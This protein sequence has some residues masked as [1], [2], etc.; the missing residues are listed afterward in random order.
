MI[1]ISFLVL[2]IFFGF[3]SGITPGPLL[4][5]VVSETLKNNKKE[6]IKVAIA[7][8]IT[9]APIILLTYLIVSKLSNFNLILGFISIL[10]SIFIG[11]LAYK[12]IFF[13]HSESRNVEKLRS[14]EKGIIVNLL[15]PHPY[16][17]WFT[18]GTP[19]LLKTLNVGFYMAIL[20]LVG[21]YI[22]LFGSQIL[23]III[24]DKYKNFLR[25]VIYEYLIKFTGILLLFFAFL[26]LLDG[27]KFFGVYAL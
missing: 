24:V 5:L 9:D 13:R 25:S 2:G 20:F 16:L 23:I 4:T 6:G 26:F 11:Y 27:L 10:G 12:N 15:N 18:V 17:F 21:F 7:P 14:L 1:D 8:L 3:Y 22:F 19:T